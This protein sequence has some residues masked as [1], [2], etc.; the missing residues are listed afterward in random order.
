MNSAYEKKAK[1]S[2][3]VKVL[4]IQSNSDTQMT[5]KNFDEISEKIENFF[6]LE[7]KIL[8]KIS[9]LKT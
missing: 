6:L 4:L 9:K 1:L 8:K 2:N 3:I 5:E 7:D